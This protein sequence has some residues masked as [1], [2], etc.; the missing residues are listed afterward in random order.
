[1]AD[2]QSLTAAENDRLENIIAFGEA[3]LAADN[4]DELLNTAVRNA[5]E[6]LGA[7]HAKILV[8]QE[9]GTLLV[10]A[11]IGWSG[12]VVGRATIKGDTFSPPGFALKTLAP[13]QSNNFETE[14]RFR[15]PELLRTHNIKSAINVPIISDKKPFGVLEV[16]STDVRDFTAQDT[17]FLQQ[18]SQ[19][20]ASAIWRVRQSEA[21][22]TIAQENSMLLKE[23]HHRIGNDF[24]L[25]MSLI[26]YRSRQITD[27]AAKTELNWVTARL[28]AL[29]NLHD[30]LRKTNSSRKADLGQY[31]LS[32]CAQLSEAN[33]L[34]NRK[35]H[36]NVNV[37]DWEM[38]AGEVISV[39][40]IL[41]EFVTNSVEHAFEDD[42]GRIYVELTSNADSARLHL[43]DNGKGFDSSALSTR[44]GFGLMR[45]LAQT[46]STDVQEDTQNGVHFILHLKPQT[47]PQ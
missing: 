3:A 8:P 27:D 19:L 34:S 6:G 33:N 24:Q 18:Y 22:K 38:E 42:E 17:A 4:L 25:V 45:T 26:N 41:N 29:A 31:I 36:L 39:G 35:I 21:L 32:M 16:D 7:H 23:L 46:I 11:G 14:T 9:D 15:V 47:Q 1:M 13:V 28:Q 37:D 44:S 10:I 12:G 43:S 30:L 20:L 40:L 5:A 2:N